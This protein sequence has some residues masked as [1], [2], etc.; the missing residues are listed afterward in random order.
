MHI[1]VLGEFR[2]RDMHARRLKFLY[3]ARP[4]KNES[5]ILNRV[6]SLSRHSR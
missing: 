5:G 4:I 1:A 6:I 2:C 3:Q